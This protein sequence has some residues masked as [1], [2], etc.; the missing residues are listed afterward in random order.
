MACSPV[1]VRAALGTHFLHHVPALSS[2]PHPTQG[3]VIPSLSLQGPLPELLC[4]PTTYPATPELMPFW[5]WEPGGELRA[6]GLGHQFLCPQ[7]RCLA[8]VPGASGGWTVPRALPPVQSSAL[9]KGLTRPATLAATA[10]P[11][12]SCWWVSS[13]PGLLWAWGPWVAGKG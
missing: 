3:P 6:P 12:R 5:V 1:Q 11:E 4:S 10:L 8:C 2:H 13:P 9:L 7:G